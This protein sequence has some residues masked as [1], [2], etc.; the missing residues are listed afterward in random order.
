MSNSASQH[1]HTH[2]HTHSYTEGPYNKRSEG[3][4]NNSSSSAKC[5]SAGK[6]A[7]VHLC[8][9]ILLACYKKKEILSFATA[10]S[11]DGPGECYA[12]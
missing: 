12:K 3:K 7:T 9:G 10:W 11:T 8:N 2:T 6:K 5:P 4:K 1:T